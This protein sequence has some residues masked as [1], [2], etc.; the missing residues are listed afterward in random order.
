MSARYGIL[1]FSLIGCLLT[2]APAMAADAAA[3]PPAS[4]A[5]RLRAIA[6]V[7]LED[8]D[9]QARDSIQ[10]A[11]R[12]LNEVLQV[13]PV[14]TDKLAAAYGE[15]G[16]LYQAHL[17]FPAAEDC[18]HN[19]HQLAPDEFRWAYYGAYLA[20]TDGRTRQALER[21]EHA[22]T[23][24]PG[25]K[26][27]TLRL[28][29]VLLDLNELEGAQAAYEQ[30][31]DATGLEA[32]ALYG[33][34]QIA[35]LKHEYDTA[36]DAFTRALTYDPAASSIHY[37]LAQALRATNRN[38]E[39]K[40]QLALRGKQSP[41]FRDPQIESLNALKIGSRIHFLRAMKAIRQQ[42]YAAANQAFA[43]GLG[44][45]P[46]NVL[47]RI[48]YARTLYLIDDKASARTELEKV[49]AAQPDN[50]LGLFLMG[51][52]SEEEG[53]ASKAA[54]YYRRAI[55]HTPDHAGA[56]FFLASQYYRQGNYTA[57]AR[58]YASSIKGEK[59]NLAAY[60]PYIGTLILSDAPAATLKTVLEKAIQQ[61]PENTGFQAML[62]MLQAA[63]RDAA[64]QA[65][66][67]ALKSAKQLNEQLRIPP[68]QELVALAYAANGSYAQA[69]AIQEELLAYARQNMPAEADRVART[70]AYYQ[71]GTCPPLDELIDRSVLKAPP[72][73]ATAAIRDYPAARPY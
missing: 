17:V 53:D 45:E 13:Q 40:A 16:G 11:R 23:L 26:A 32:A 3:N 19:A 43:E 41:S 29:N 4:L 18:F 2:G 25:Y 6:E 34:G 8:M 63:S 27:L 60:I 31:V 36:I 71:Q 48:S 47:A 15:L 68:H 52:L 28:G 12:Q 30:V 44:M 59:S 72:F 51:I 9:V 50:S 33:L 42:D 67:T 56:H 7:N 24:N 64:V 70:L 57:A 58:H 1:L 61:F 21:Y 37:P 14:Q 38:D 10:A 73:N 39:A 46:D 65:P 62:I 5:N 69:T 54:D 55:S 20:E 66:D 35:L 22:R 49:I